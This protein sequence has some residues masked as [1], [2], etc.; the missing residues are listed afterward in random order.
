MKGLNVLDIDSIVNANSSNPHNVLG[1]HMENVNGTNYV[2]VRVF[3]PHAKDVG[4]IVLDQEQKEYPFRKVHDSGFYYYEVLSD[5]F[6]EYKLKFYYD[7]EKEYITYDPYRFLPTISEF[8]LHLFA[9]GTHYEIYNKMGAKFK[10][11]DDVHGVSFTV[12]APNAKR[13][14]VIG[15]FNCWDGRCSPMRMLGSSGVWELFI[16]GLQ[17]FD[18]YKYEIKTQSGDLIEKADPYSNFH[19]LRPSESSIL[20]NIEGFE[21][22][23]KD[24]ITNRQNNNPLGNAMSIYEV[25]LG[26]W[27]RKVEEDNRYLSY[28]ELS[29]TLIPYVL[30]MGYTHI[31]LMGIM[32]HPFDGSWGYQVT[33]YYASTSR[34]GNPHELM[35]FIDKCHEAGI[36]VILD[37]V[38]GHF[39]KDAF[40][41]AKFDGTCLYEHA[42]PLKGEHPEWGT[43]IFNYSRGEV[44]NFLI[45][46][47]LYW[48]EKFHFDGIRIDAVAS[49]LYLDYGR[50]ST[51]YIPNEFGGRE[52]LEAIEFL[53]SLN[54]VV[55]GRDNSYLMIAEESTSWEGVTRPAK[56]GGLGFN[57]KWNM[58]FMN[59]TLKYIK[60]DPINRK[61]HHNLLT[62]GMMYAYTE[63]FVLVLSHDEVVHGKGSMIGK[64]PG[65]TWQKFANLKSFY[66]FTFSH[67][68]KKLLFMGQDFGQF[69]E[70]NEAKSLDWNLLDFDTHKGLSSYVK[71]LNHFYK[72]NSAMWTYDFDERGFL[73]LDVNNC[74]YSIIAFLRKTSNV[75]ETIVAINNFTPIVHMKYKLWLPFECELVEA[76]NSDDLKY[77]GSGVV[78]TINP[79]TYLENNQYF[80]DVVVPPLAS[81]YFK[82]K[83]K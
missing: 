5:E 19:E 25:H 33:G 3:A 36:G 77:N 53:K 27:K 39:V 24:Y 7:N 1:Q 49:M 14:S 45:G 66:G 47:A 20:F 78:N 76:L 34:Y 62:F 50:Q 51:G 72:S 40:G 60:E 26:S 22:H 18:R 56:W 63:N 46:S 41:I 11:V 28:L 23:D 73:W 32:E 21:W 65:D 69:A 29:D 10:V 4:I 82:V 52:N 83:V 64:M 48:L 16:P 57:L 75:N 80:A 15:D 44:K 74:D 79:K 67:P 43:L 81:L 55:L 59:D 71:D 61:Y 2:S 38:P 17:N 9:S 12:W 37:W 42:D 58:G 6:F 35:H 70:W 8:D 13:V 31:E 68:G 30:E 54:S